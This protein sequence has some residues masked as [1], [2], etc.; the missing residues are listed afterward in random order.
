MKL[1]HLESD[2]KVIDL[3][4]IFKATIEEA[5]ADIEKGDPFASLKKFDKTPKKLGCMK[6]NI[7][8]LSIMELSF[9]FFMARI[10]A[11]SSVEK[12]Q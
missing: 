11:K 4:K 7:C 8:N 1:D 5:I 3:R 12:M 10:S 9:L 6:Y 2:L